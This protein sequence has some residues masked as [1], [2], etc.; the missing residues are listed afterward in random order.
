[1]IREYLACWEQGTRLRSSSK[2]S[3]ERLNRQSTRL[4]WVNRKA[5]RILV[6]ISSWCGEFCCGGMRDASLLRMTMERLL[7][8]NR[9]SEGG[10]ATPSSC[11]PN[12]ALSRSDVRS[13]GDAGVGERQTCEL[14][15]R[16]GVCGDRTCKT[17]LSL[18]SLIEPVNIHVAASRFAL[19]VLSRPVQH[20]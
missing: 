19:C 5:Y 15:G 3:Q 12:A 11:Q 9:N 18:V 6:Q 4:M 16:A 14:G 13:C 17:S 7:S 10:R 2:A 1:M 8:C 20:V